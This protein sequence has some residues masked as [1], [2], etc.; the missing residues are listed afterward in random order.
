MA[1]KF[2]IN[3]KSYD[4]V[5]VLIAKFNKLNEP[6]EAPELNRVICYFYSILKKKDIHQKISKCS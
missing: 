1:N 5:K 2:E 6:S 4:S 3:S